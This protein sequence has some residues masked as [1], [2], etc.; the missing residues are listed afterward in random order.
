MKIK[1]TYKEAIEILESQAISKKGLERVFL[2][3]SLG[4]ILA[5][6]IIAPSDMPQC[7]LSN[8]DGYAISSKFIDE[9]N[10]K[11]LQENPAGR[12][13]SLEIPLNAPY[14]IKTFTGARIPQNADIL[15]P[16]EFVKVS[17]ECLEILQLPK[18]GEFIRQK[19]ANYKKGEI[20]L[21]KG[22]RINANH[23]GLLA[24]LNCVFVE[25][26]E[27]VKVGILVS[28]NEIVELGNSTQEGQVY[29]ANGH[30]LF[31]KIKEI[32]ANPKLYGILKDNKEEIEKALNL[33]LSECDLII[34]SGGASVGD[35]DFISAL[36]KERENEVVF[37]GV[38][39]KPGQHVIYAHFNNKQ[40]F[41]LPGFPN[42]TL[43][44][45][46]LLVKRILAKM[47]GF[48]WMP[49]ALELP[50]QEGIKKSDNR[51]EF[52]VCNLRNINGKFSIDFIDKK[53]F[54]S[55]ILNNFCPL[56]SVICALCVLDG[57]KNSGEL[58]QVL[59]L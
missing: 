9:K 53:D 49:L 6:D 21:K 10:F 55:A 50:L 32:G 59:I 47:Q 7:A 23:I 51:L 57:E 22:T 20:L 11:I 33:A 31:A 54:Q 3:D 58:V 25:V 28:G 16:I 42:A 17:G 56:D 45:F 15:V 26:Y 44:T 52:R 5:Q 36:C 2:H 35:Y 41:A 18:V 19:G 14:A 4:R 38:Q 27:K 34:T 40:F 46:E 1:I 43:V 13:E 24:S 12:L 37:K 30:L 29:N 8:M 39:I 48:N